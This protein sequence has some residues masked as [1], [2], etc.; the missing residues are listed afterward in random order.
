MTPRLAVR[1]TRF[2][3]A[4]VGVVAWLAVSA[5]SPV[6]AD[7]G[8]LGGRP[9]NPRADNP[10]T[11]S[12]FIHELAPGKEAADGVQIINGTSETKK[13]MVYAVDSQ[14]ASG[15]SF[16]CAQAADKPIS[17]G[18][19]VAMSKSQITL[20]PGTRQVVD[21]TIKVP[22][23]ASPGEHNGCIVIQDTERQRVAEGG[24]IVLSMRS[25]IR[26]AVT[27]P[28]DIKKG[29]VFTGVGVQ[30][31][32]SD[33]VLMSASLRNSGNVSLD[34]Q[35]DVRLKYALGASAASAGG[36][37]PVLSASEAKF[38]FEGSRPF[39]GGWYRLVAKAQYNN[40]PSAVL[41]EGAL[42]ASA[43][44]TSWV[45][46]SPQPVA[47]AI[48]GATVGFAA[49]GAGVYAQRRLIKRKAMSHAARHTVEANENL[50]TI[51]ERYHISWKLLARI[52]KLK[53]PYQLTPGQSIVVTLA[54][55]NERRRQ[56]R[57]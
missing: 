46:I 34:S 15:G 48:E 53:P 32:G 5:A 51:A 33:K 37:F 1:L 19:W 13:V 9:A 3:L 11:K 52:N 38:N 29:L 40:T 36:S 41:G 10:R 21:F 26:L 28:G 56:Q 18:A 4:I 55:T 50:H 39:W 30:A 20:A 57:R 6:V 47:A 43:E 25:A 14:L 7:Q 24:G 42:N 54:K 2:L 45:F 49:V 22:R 12:I 35:L 17:V 23:D 27:V 44:Q 16:A 31:R 8:S